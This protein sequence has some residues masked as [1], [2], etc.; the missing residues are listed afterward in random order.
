MDVRSH[1]NGATM[2]ITDNGRGFPQGRNAKHAASGLGLRN[3]QERIEQLNGTLRIQSTASGTIMHYQLDW[4]APYGPLT[5]P[6]LLGV[7]GG[8]LMTA[9]AAY[10]AILKRRADPA[11]GG[12]AVVGETAFVL[13]LGAVGATGLSLYAATGT[14]LVPALLALHL[15]CVLAFFL[16]TPY[17]KM[18]HGAYRFA[19]LV[20]EA[21]LRR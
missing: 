9:G 11:L 21:Q 18:A 16:T 12:D 15:G 3:M 4:P 14:T 8:A 13:L 20:R 1:K 10:L 6:K 19:A 7:P 2:R 17:S 5:P